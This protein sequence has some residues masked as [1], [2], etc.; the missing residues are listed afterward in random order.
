[1]SLERLEGERRNMTESID[2]TR[3]EVLGTR[4]VAGVSVPDSPLITDAL[5][6]A[7]KLSE[8]YLFN[9]A[10]RSWLPP[11]R[12]KAGDDLRQFSPRFRRA[13][14]ARLQ[15]DIGRRSLMNAPFEE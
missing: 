7:Q 8:P 13:L 9:H 1:M 15:A 11:R 4:L 2:V 12:R 3:R 10:A 5:E 6:Y 14:R